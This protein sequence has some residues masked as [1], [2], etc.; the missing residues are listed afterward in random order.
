MLLSQINPLYADHIDYLAQKAA[1]PSLWQA[2]AEACAREARQDFGSADEALD[3]LHRMQRLRQVFVA[4]LEND[5]AFHA[6]FV[7]E[8]AALPLW[9][10]FSLAARSGGAAGT[11]SDTAL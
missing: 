6:A 1:Q 9:H 7:K 10:D 4:G 3:M 11:S 8:Q 5:A 2:V